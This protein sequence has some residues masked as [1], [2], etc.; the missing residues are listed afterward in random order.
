[1]RLAHDRRGSG[2]ALVL[3]HGLGSH[4]GAWDPVIGKL[5]A[6]REVFALDLPGFGESEPLPAGLEPD[7]QTLADV[8]EQFAGELG[9]DRPHVAGNSLGG[10]VALE[11]AR[12]GS[13]GSVTALSPIGFMGGEGEK[14]FVRGSL[15]A[16]RLMA[17]RLHPA[18]RLLSSAPLRT[19]LYWQMFAR[20]W[21]IPPA[22]AVRDMAALA[23]CPSFEAALAG[24]IEY[25]AP[26]A[27]DLRVPVTIAWGPRDGLLL[28]VQARR[29]RRRL[30]KA[31]HV[32]L[33]GCG[34]LPMS[35]DPD[36][37]AGVILAGSAP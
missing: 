20:P 15:R 35:D 3:I 25:S 4:R 21:R 33:R 18:P 9:L 30:P 12:R 34:H 17:R 16:S 28:P 36:R 24:T 19:L 13:V 1:M 29:A 2:P 11:L 10:G 8:V 31:R 26:A 27:Q 32:W 22:V 37:V 14:R 7:V 6:E 5:A 23:S